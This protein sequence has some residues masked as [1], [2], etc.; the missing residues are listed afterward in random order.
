MCRTL[1]ARSAPLPIRVTLDFTGDIFH[2]P[3]HWNAILADHLCRITSLR[4]IFLRVHAEAVQSLLT[5]WD[6]RMGQLTTL[7]L[8]VP[9]GHGH[10]VLTLPPT[11]A[12]TILR[13]RTR[14]VF[15]H[16]TPMWELRSLEIHCRSDLRE[17]TDWVYDQPLVLLDM[18]ARC[19]N[20][21]SLALYYAVPNWSQSLTQDVVTPAGHSGTG[22]SLWIKHERK[23]RIG[24]GEPPTLFPAE[25]VY[26]CGTVLQNRGLG[27]TQDRGRHVYLSKLKKLIVL[28]EPLYIEAFLSHLRVF[29]P[30]LSQRHRDPFYHIILDL[31]AFNTPFHMEHPYQVSDLLRSAY[32]EVV[33][34][35]VSRSESLRI[36]IN[37]D[38]TVQ[39]CGRTG[40]HERALLT[41]R[42]C[43]E[44]D[45]RAAEK[46]RSSA[47]PACRSRLRNVAFSVL[48][49]V[50]PFISDYCHDLTWDLLQEVD[51][52][53]FRHVL[54]RSDWPYFLQ[55]V[56]PPSVKT[57]FVGGANL[58]VQL[59]Q[60]FKDF[61]GL[62]EADRPPPLSLSTIVCCLPSV[63]AG[64][65]I[66]GG[67]GESYPFP[68]KRVV[69]RVPTL[70]TADHA[71]SG[72]S[73]T[74]LTP[75]ANSEVQDLMRLY[76]SEDRG[77]VIVRHRTCAW[78]R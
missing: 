52:H 48:S 2:A 46:H 41:I 20:V 55:N 22:R 27:T 31:R 76:G 72:P 8:E 12:S 3:P 30:P 32:S 56:L 64:Q 59:L 4:V 17:S 36:C 77:E 25:G 28:D 47:C 78:H 5:L 7:S 63:Q 23:I 40:A 62:P 21:E 75:S 1:L 71:N 37:P 66:I 19:C 15:T 73:A 10:S 54:V 33:P 49:S 68:I 42:N 44:C 24:C 39:V 6:M 65:E 57:L 9:D 50:L 43:H 34:A 29:G 67:P 53:D 60:A 45:S 13:L 38:G 51:I 16:E 70:T 14:S 35:V 11:M 58:S 18:L 61:E 74:P 26:T 69:F